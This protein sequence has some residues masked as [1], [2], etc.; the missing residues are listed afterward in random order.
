[1]PSSRAQFLRIHRLPAGRALELYPAETDLDP[2][3]AKVQ[4]PKSKVH[5]PFRAAAAVRVAGRLVGRGGPA[6][7]P[8]HLTPRLEVDGPREGEGDVDAIRRHAVES[9]RPGGA[10]ETARPAREGVSP[11]QVR[12]RQSALQVGEELVLIGAREGH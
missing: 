9:G 2:A 7:R 12:R 5:E 4:S 11:I 8:A 3:P 1:M 6:G 10:A